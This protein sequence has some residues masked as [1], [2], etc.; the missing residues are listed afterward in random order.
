[1]SEFRECRSCQTGP[2]RPLLDLGKQPLA[3]NLLRDKDLTRDEPRFSLILTVCESCDLLQIAETVPPVD[4][5][6]DYVYF[7][8]FSDTMLRHAQEAS[9][10][11]MEEFQLSRKSLVVEI[12]S[13]DGYLLKNFKEQEVPCV[14]VEP[15][16]NIAR[17][18]HEKGVDTI[19]EFFTN[20]FAEHFVGERGGADLVLGNNVFAHVPTINDFVAGLKT[21]LTPN[22]CI[23][24][25]FPYAGDFMEKCEFD[26]VYHEHVFYFA[27][28]PLEPLFKKHGLEIFNVER[29]PIHGGSLRLFAGHL[30]AREATTAVAD[31]RAA[32]TDR[33]KFAGSAGV[34]FAQRVHEIRNNLRSM[35]ERLKADGRFLAAYGASAKGSTLLNFCWP[36]G[37]PLDFIADRSTAKHGRFSPGSHVPIVAAEEL[38]ARQPDYTLLLTWNF[39]DEIFEQQR[40]YREAGG[41]FIIPVPQPHIV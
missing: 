4:L 30:G 21:I 16:E 33:G 35:V 11:Y 29:L 39:A 17:V 15:A 8:S 10:R 18:A 24:L 20:E 34:V 23:V 7:S 32:E 40:V 2:L 22:G 19:A 38:A 37:A 14:G 27:L 25:E 28:S 6:S 9:I 26:T 13:N 3:N 41:R 31:L 1:M 5:F 12:A 36:E